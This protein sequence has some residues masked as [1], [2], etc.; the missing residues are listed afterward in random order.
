MIIGNKTP[1][2]RAVRHY[3]GRS[4][5]ATLFRWLNRAITGE[6]HPVRGTIIARTGRVK[7]FA[8]WKGGRHV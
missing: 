4:R 5:T 3:D 6:H 1:D 7:F 8:R 2:G